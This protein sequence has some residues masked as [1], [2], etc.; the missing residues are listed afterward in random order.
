MQNCGVKAEAE[1]RYACVWQQTTK[2]N[3]LINEDT[4][5]VERCKQYGNTLECTVKTEAC[6]VAVALRR[7]LRCMVLSPS[8]AAVAAVR[9]T[10]EAEPKLLPEPP[11]LLRR[12]WC[13]FLGDTADTRAEA[14]SAV[15][16][17]FLQTAYSFE[18]LRLAES[19]GGL[20]PAYSNGRLKPTYSFERF[21][22]A[23]TVGGDQAHIWNWRDQAP[24]TGSNQWHNFRGSK[25]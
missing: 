16:L 18:R 22:P 7:R 24:G 5:K 10:V 14:S 13:F 21:R 23:Y 8:G 4:N 11:S 15:C 3:M 9:P 19:T 2:R 1:Q 25:Q 20:K 6:L 12:R 17:C